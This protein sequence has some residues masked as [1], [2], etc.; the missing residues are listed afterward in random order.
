MLQYTSRW[1]LTSPMPGQSESGKTATL[2]S[3]DR[4]Y[5]APRN[6]ANHISDFQ[7]MYNKHEWTEERASWRA[8]IYL[9]L[10]RNVNRI[11]ELMVREISDRNLYNM[12][13]EVSDDS[14]EEIIIAR[15]RSLPPLRFQEKHRLLQQR[16]RPL[17]GVQKELESRLGA[18]AMELHS[19]SVT[20]AAPFE[21]PTST[22]RRGFSEFSIHSSNGWKSAL[23]KLRT[24]SS[25]PENERDALKKA[26]D[27]DEDF[28]ETL[29]SCQSAIRELWEDSVVQEMLNRRKIRLEDAPGL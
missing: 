9:N 8:V 3:T 23:G 10:V 18:G 26:N 20:T 11:L 27:L 13:G 28:V 24:R 2:K 12:D 15:A 22:R 1:A 4:R 25:P 29:V 16:L 6:L 5:G 21:V 7:L 19:T 14:M 17:L